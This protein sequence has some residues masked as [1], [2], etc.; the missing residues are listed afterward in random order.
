MVRVAE[1]FNVCW[2]AEPC[3]PQASNVSSPTAAS[4]FGIR[5]IIP[6]LRLQFSHQP[7]RANSNWCK[8]TRYNTIYD[9]HFEVAQLS[10]TASI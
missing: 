8:T 9:N 1:I 3:G 5:D 2:A 7:Q 6:V 4:S 10:A